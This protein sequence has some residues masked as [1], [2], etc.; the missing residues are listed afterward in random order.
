MIT[1]ATDFLSN[2]YAAALL[3]VILHLFY[4]CLFFF[5]FLIFSLSKP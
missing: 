5:F 1:K 3:G 2:N 4:L